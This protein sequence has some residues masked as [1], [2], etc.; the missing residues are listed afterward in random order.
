MATDTYSIQAMTIENGEKAKGTLTLY[1]DRYEFRYGGNGLKKDIN[2]ENASCKT[3]TQEVKTFLFKSEK[4]FVVIAEGENYGPRFILE[5]GTEEELVSKVSEFGKTVKANRLAEEERRRKEEEE[6]KRK[7]AEERKRKEEEERRRKEEERKRKEEEERKRKEEEERKRKEAEERKRKEAEE[8]KALEKKLN[9]RKKR[10]EA[11][12]AASTTPPATYNLSD[13]ADLAIKKGLSFINENPY[14]ILGISA[15]AT[16][17]EA[18]ASLDKLKKLS[19]LNATASFKSEYHLNGTNKPERDISIAQNA[20]TIIKDIRYKWLWFADPDACLAWQNE[21]YRKELDRDGVEYGT[22]D[23]FLANYFYALASDPV[24]QNASAWKSV[25]KFYNHICSEVNCSLLKSRFSEKEL[26]GIQ[27]RDI[28]SSFMSEIFKPLEA[29]CESEDVLITIRLYKILKSIS[30]KHLDALKKIVTSKLSNWFSSKEE[31]VCLFLKKYDDQDSITAADSRE[32]KNVGD[33]YLKNVKSIF[34]TALSAVD[35]EKVRYDMIKESFRN[36]TWQLMFVLNKASDKQNAIFFANKT[37]PYCTD[38]DKR[39][40]RNTFGFN[41]IKGCDRDVTNA[42]WDIMGDNYFNG[43]NGYEVDYYEAFK[44]Y[45]KAADA[46]NKYSQ[47]SLGICYKEGKGTYQSDYEAASW[48]E[49]AYRNGNP[50][51]AYN[52]ANCYSNGEGRTKDRKRALDLYVEAAKMGHPNAAAAGQ[53]LI[54]LMALEQKLHRLS[55]HNHYDIGFQVIYGQTIIVEVTLNYSANVYLM[56]DDDYDN[57]RQCENF[58]YYGGRASQSPYRVKIPHTGH[59][60]LV[61]DNGDDDMT[62]IYASVQTRTFN[63]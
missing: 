24:F 32:V 25:F 51:G 15:A 2:W 9:D 20:L 6:R 3:G 62:G 33:D 46:G 21:E 48:F 28:Q 7:E 23:L 41:A 17:E 63:F 45:K 42:E 38:E 53:A 56:E 19:R 12:I 29:I 59:W 57:Y 8:R 13:S 31:A 44:W 1:L 36:T 26:Q 50:D 61:I 30:E 52:L 4:P 60:H 27:N 35:G 43:D 40:V 55:Q 37:Y 10:I 47:N 39:K 18:N 34:E 54:A 5:K 49:K 11:E 16:S 58:S 14:R 22:Y